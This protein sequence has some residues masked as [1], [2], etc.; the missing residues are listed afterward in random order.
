MDRKNNEKVGIRRRISVGRGAVLRGVP[1]YVIITD[2]KL[3]WGG[4]RKGRNITTSCVKNE[5][6]QVMLSYA[7]LR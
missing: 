2:V 3:M 6:P 4:K 5:Y 7:K 1:L